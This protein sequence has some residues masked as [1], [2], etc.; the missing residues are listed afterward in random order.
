MIASNYLVISVTDV[1]AATNNMTRFPQ[2]LASQNSEL[3][4]EYLKGLCFERKDNIR[5]R[6]Q[7]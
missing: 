3:L 4:L 6:S 2:Y 1:V 5:S 7:E